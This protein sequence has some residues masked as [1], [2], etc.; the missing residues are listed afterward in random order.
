MSIANYN[1][2][3]LRDAL[4][5]LP[6]SGSNGFEGLLAT[7]FAKLLGVPFRLAQSGSQFGVDG[8]TS[9]P[10]FPVAFEAERYRDDVPSKE[11]LNKIGALAIRDDPVELWILGTTGIVASQVADDLAALAAIHGYATLILDWQPAAPRLAA[12]LM[13]ASAEV[14]DFLNQNVPTTGLAAK[15][16]VELQ[17]LSGRTDL[18]DIAQSA[19]CQLRAASVATPMAQGANRRWLVETLSN[20]IRAKSRLGQVLTPLDA[21]GT[22]NRP[23]LPRHL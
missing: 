12:V 6:S 14:G 8:K 11:V 20:Q 16:V 13:E 22:L 10:A 4:L 18:A 9:D 21:G 19:L 2:T 3:A 23:G 7:V 17:S 5:D 1:L 15:A